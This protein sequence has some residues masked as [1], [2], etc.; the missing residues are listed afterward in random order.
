MQKYLFLLLLFA[1]LGCTHTRKV[2]PLSVNTDNVVALINAGNW[3][4]SYYDTVYLQ[5]GLTQR[6][7]ITDTTLGVTKIDDSS[8]SIRGISDPLKYMGT[9]SAQQ[10]ATYGNNFVVFGTQVIFRYYYAANTLTYYMYTTV[11]AGEQTIIE[12]NLSSH[13]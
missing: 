10:M 3:S 2:S 13:W 6:R 9:D 1:A 7:T 11:P 5:P 8:F 4:G 12:V